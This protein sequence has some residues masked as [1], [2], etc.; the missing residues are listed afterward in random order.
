MLFFEGGFRQLDIMNFGLQYLVPLRRILLGLLDLCLQVF[1][2]CRPLAFFDLQD[3]LEL[4]LP[5][6]KLLVRNLCL[7]HIA[8]PFLRLLGFKQRLDVFFLLSLAFG[9]RRR[10]LGGRAYPFNSP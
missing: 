8:T 2:S 4:M 9:I 7:I 6:N 10:S 1:F 3:T 5:L